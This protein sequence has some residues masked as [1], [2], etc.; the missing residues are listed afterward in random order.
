MKRLI[1]IPVIALI[2]VSCKNDKD[3]ALAAN[4]N[5][6]GTI[7]AMRL[8][9]EEQKVAL[10]KQSVID[11]M[12]M[13]NEL[14]LPTDYAIAPEPKVE[15]RVVYAKAP[16]RRK[17]YAAPAPVQAPVETPVAIQTPPIAESPAP[18]P[19]ESTIPATMP[20]EKEKKGWSN[21]AKGAV[22]GAGVGAIGGAVI[23]KRN[24]V[25]G[26]VLGGLIGAAAGAGTGILIDK[27]QR[28]NEF[29]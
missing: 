11:S 14:K 2:M 10:A 4:D 21:T 12:Q 3:Q 23:N 8:Q 28:Q 20:V 16:K 18:G 9:L 17:Q 22:I 1:L 5:M 25:K 26:A 7:E 15:R 24:R 6:N 13:I 29:Q 19:V 27:K